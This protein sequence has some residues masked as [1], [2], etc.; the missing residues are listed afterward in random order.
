MIKNLAEKIRKIRGD[1]PVKEFAAKLGTTPSYIYRLESGSSTTISAT[2]V[3]LLHEKFGVSKE[4]LID[5]IGDMYRRDLISVRGPFE[6]K[7]APVPVVGKVPAGYPEEAMEII[8]YRAFPEAPPGAKAVIVK[9]DSMAPTIKD[10]DYA[11]WISVTDI[12]HNDVVIV[13]DEWGDIMLKRIKM[14]G[15]RITLVSDNPEYPAFEPNV[16]Y[17]LIGK[18]VCAVRI[19]LIG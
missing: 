16:H 13:A 3:E 1:M 11:L 19:T 12:K 6:V 17:R 4:W 9:G 5:D 7:L 15:D 10:G 14:S 2:V 8:E 18:V